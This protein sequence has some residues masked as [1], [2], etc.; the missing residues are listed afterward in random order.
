LSTAATMATKSA[1]TGMMRRRSSAWG[2]ACDKPPA[3]S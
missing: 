1:K 3:T 2:G